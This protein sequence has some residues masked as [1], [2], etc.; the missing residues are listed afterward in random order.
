MEKD[1]LYFDI[2]LHLGYWSLKNLINVP[3]IVVVEAS[4]ITYKLLQ[5]NLA[6]KSDQI[7]ELCSWRL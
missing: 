3:K 6:D 2:G 4:Y 5:T 7:I 1:K